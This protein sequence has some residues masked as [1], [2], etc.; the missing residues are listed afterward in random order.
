MIQRR[1]WLTPGTLRSITEEVPLTYIATGKG[2]GICHLEKMGKDVPERGNSMCK[3]GRK[4]NGTFR[5][6]VL[7]STGRR[8]LIGWGVWEETNLERGIGI[9]LGRSLCRVRSL[10]LTCHCSG[11]YCSARLSAL[12]IFIATS[13]SAPLVRP[14]VHQQIF[15]VSGEPVPRFPNSVLQFYNLAFCCL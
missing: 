3:G 12:F 1:R 9:P 14:S 10:V 8:G 13:R 7:S 6:A 11:P 2:L 4:V 5:G 15:T